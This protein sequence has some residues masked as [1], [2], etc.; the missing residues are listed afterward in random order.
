MRDLCELWYCNPN[1][2]G[3]RVSDLGLTGLDMKL[4][5]AMQ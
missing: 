1:L 2:L 5:Q 4:F 3:S